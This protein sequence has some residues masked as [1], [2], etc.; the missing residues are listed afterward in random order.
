MSYSLCPSFVELHGFFPPQNAGSEF[1]VDPDKHRR[2][3]FLYPDTTKDF[4][5]LPL[6][7]RVRFSFITTPSPSSHHHHPHTC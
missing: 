2:A 5:L 4:D 7:F 1:R 6:E 3:E